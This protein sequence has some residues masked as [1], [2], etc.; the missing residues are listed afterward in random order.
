M[1]HA[2]HHNTE[3]SYCGRWWCK[4]KPIKLFFPHPLLLLLPLLTSN[5]IPSRPRAPPHRLTWHRPPCPHTSWLA[6]KMDQVRKCQRAHSLLYRISLAFYRDE[7]VNPASTGQ[8][9]ENQEACIA[10]PPTRI[11]WSKPF[12]RVDLFAIK[13]AGPGDLYSLPAPSL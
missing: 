1:L 6:I 5:N 4:D 3:K 11:S 12:N 7:P 10:L 13:D 9:L 8:G 2:F